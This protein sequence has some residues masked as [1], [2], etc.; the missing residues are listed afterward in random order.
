MQ[1]TTFDAREK[2]ELLSKGFSPDEI[3]QLEIQRDPSL[4]AEYYLND[5]EKPRVP[6]KL[7]D[8]QKQMI[9]YQGRKKV[10]RCGRRIGKSVSLAIEALWLAFVNEGIRI[11]ICTPYKQ[12]TANLWKD[13]FNKLI[14]GN[15]LLESSISKSLQNPYLIEFK[16]GARILGLTAGSSTGNKGASIRGQN[17]DVLILDEVDYMGEEAIQ[18]IQAIS[19]TSRKTRVIIS[20]TPTGKRE[21]F[22]EACFRPGTKIMTSLGYKNIENFN[23]SDEILGMSGFSENVTKTYINEYNDDLIKCSLKGLYKKLESTKKHPI[24]SIKKRVGYYTPEWIEAVDLKVDDY[25]GITLPKYKHKNLPFIDD[26]DYTTDKRILKNSKNTIKNLIIGGYNDIRDSRKISSLINANNEI[27]RINSNDEL[28]KDFME[29]LGYYLAEGNLIKDKVNNPVGLNLTFKLN[30]PIVNRTYD[31]FKLLWPE[32]TLKRSIKKI[33]SSEHIQFYSSE[34]ALIFKNYIGEYSDTKKIHVDLLGN[35]YISKLINAYGKGD[36]HINKNECQSYTTVSEELADQIWRYLLSN[37]LRASIYKKDAI[38][39]H[40]ESYTVY[41]PKKQKSKNF[42]WYNKM[43]F[44]KIES[45]QFEKYEGKVYNLETNRTHTYSVNGFAVHNCTNKNLGFQEF[46]FSACMSPEWLSIDECRKKGLPLHESQEYLFRNTVP[47]AEYK[48]EYEAEFGEET[49]GVFKHRYID[50]SLITY[51]PKIEQVDAKGMCWYCGDDQVDGNFYSMGVDWNGTKVGTQIVIT[52]YCL[53]PTTIR[54]ISENADGGVS[55]ESIVVIKKYR[56]FYRESVSLEKMTQLE[57]I[58]RIIEL[59]KRFRIN[60][61]Y[62]DAGFG[63]TNI[64]ELQLY[65]KKHPES[66]MHRK[67]VAIDFASKVTVFDPYSKEEV[68]KAMKPF[69]V[70]NAVTCLERNE[71]ILPDS[72]DEKVKL[73]GQMRE[74]R[75]ERISPLGTPRYTEDNDHILDAFNLSLLAFQMEYSELIR[76]THTNEVAISKRPSLLLPGLAQ[77]EDRTATITESK[78]SSLTTTKREPMLGADRYH[79]DS[80][81]KHMDYEDLFKNSPP[82]QSPFFQGGPAKTGWGKVNAPSR[83]M[84]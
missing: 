76:L 27:T 62:V 1:K 18:T 41:I 2:R 12:Q 79:S 74:Y 66:E 17:A 68:Q 40:K 77:V 26:N 35:K 80:R 55:S 5:P 31:I 19:A 81:G 47:E 63:T 65:G 56:M 4:W 69:S 53:T 21:Y 14:K 44:I 24:L 10:Y 67:L 73:V 11:L 52:E 22:Y 3:K 78:L 16:N 20:S 54:Y 38:E 23:I 61:I 64:E 7:R 45:I 25:I 60:H 72:E 49:Q 57:S 32:K 36:G 28:Q 59:T 43:P 30:E 83:S 75:I 51:D 42:I 48:H 39:E 37:G 13:G 15:I 50:S 33:N 71:L 70:N 46:H 29:L 82:T 84:F 6:L 58:S 34:I 9:S 8:Y